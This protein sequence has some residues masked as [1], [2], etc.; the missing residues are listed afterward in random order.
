MQMRDV[1]VSPGIGSPL[2]GPLALPV[3]G[4]TAGFWVREKHMSSASSSEVDSGRSAMSGAEDAE[5]SHERSA[6]LGAAALWTG[7]SERMPR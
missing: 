6:P 5:R 4:Y 1:G 3:L 7:C 2:P